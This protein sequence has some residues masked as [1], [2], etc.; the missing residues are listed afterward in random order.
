MIL[1]SCQTGEDKS[2]SFD[3]RGNIR[4]ARLESCCESQQVHGIQAEPA[5]SKSSTQAVTATLL[6]INRG[7]LPPRSSTSNLFSYEH[8]HIDDFHIR[9]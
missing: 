4:F 2:W 3:S 7:P 6:L 9:V 5:A 1:I 8:E